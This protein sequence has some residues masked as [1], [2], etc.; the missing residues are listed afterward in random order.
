MR[1]TLAKKTVYQVKGRG[2]RHFY[3]YCLIIG[4]DYR[5]TNPMYYPNEYGDALDFKN[6]R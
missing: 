4:C 1:A 3:D 6:I 2:R 5:Y